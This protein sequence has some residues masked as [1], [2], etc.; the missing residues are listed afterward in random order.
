[1][2]LGVVIPAFNEETTVGV[3]LADMPEVV[4]GHD[5]RV[6]V[7]DDG[8]TDTTAETAARHD[9]TVV[10][11]PRNKGKGSALRLGMG[12][13]NGF[14][15]DAIV[16]MDSDGQHL[17]EDLGRVVQPVLAGDADMVV[18]SRYM[19]PTRTTAPMNRRVVRKAAA[20]AIRWITG[21]RLS[22][23]FSGFRCFSPRAVAA[24]DLTGDGYESELEALFS[25]WRAGQTVL[26]VPIQKIYG[27]GMSKMGFHRGRVRGRLVVVGG[28]ARTIIGAAGRS[29]A[30]KEELVGG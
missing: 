22:D 25:I 21:I 28:Y 29:P 3:V 6:I 9:V 2:A 1:M 26:E 19:T 7:V 5:L 17:A 10:R 24:L 11:S 20:A 15:F 27:P 14:D 12:E 8:S 18:G 13:A 4:E 16:W 23:P 30:D